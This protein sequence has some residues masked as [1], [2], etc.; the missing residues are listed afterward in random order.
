MWLGERLPKSH[1]WP[2]QLMAAES[3]LF[4]WRMWPLGGWPCSSKWPKSTHILVALIRFSGFKFKKKNTWSW[5]WKQGG[6]AVF[7]ELEE[8]KRMWMW[9][10]RIVHMHGIF[11]EWMKLD[12]KKVGG[13]CQ[14]RNKRYFDLRG[15]WKDLQQDICYFQFQFFPTLCTEGKKS[16]SR[17]PGHFHLKL[18]SCF[19]FFSHKSAWQTRRDGCFVFLSALR[20]RISQSLRSKLQ[21]D[22]TNTTS[23]LQTQLWHFRSSQDRSLSLQHNA[24]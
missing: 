5:K 8:R 19:L 23:S 21:G 22:L 24:F 16:L 2:G 11:K 20:C 18:I 1:L 13:W 12:L 3:E 7:K 17:F 9:S 10:K 4:S 15:S 6:R 14:H